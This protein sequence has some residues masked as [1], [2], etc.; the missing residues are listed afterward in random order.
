MYPGSQLDSPLILDL[1]VVPADCHLEQLA[2]LLSWAM[3]TSK[4][5]RDLYGF[6]A[7]G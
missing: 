4:P 6:K 1:R 5:C 7:K 3:A 2:E